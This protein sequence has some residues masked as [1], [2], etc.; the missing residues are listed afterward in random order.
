MKSI[1]N[2]SRA[3]SAP[4]APSKSRLTRLETQLKNPDITPAGRETLERVIR[5]IKKARMVNNLLGLG[6]NGDA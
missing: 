3:E 5:A 2:D 4:P 6:D 1:K